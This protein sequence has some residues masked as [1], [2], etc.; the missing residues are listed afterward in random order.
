[1]DF[2]NV[3]DNDG[4]ILPYVSLVLDASAFFY[5][6]SASVDQLRYVIQS[7][8]KRAGDAANTEYKPSEVANVLFNAANKKS[9]A[10][11]TVGRVGLAI[12]GLSQSGHQPSIGKAINLVADSNA[13]SYKTDFQ[14]WDFEKQAFVGKPKDIAGDARAVR[15]VFDQ[16]RKV[17]HICAAR[18]ALNCYLE[19]LG[20]F[21]RA[22][23][24]DL[25]YVSTVAAFQQF[26][27]KYDKLDRSPKSEPL[28]LFHIGFISN[29]NKEIEPVTPSQELMNE[30]MGD[31]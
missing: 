4:E 1:M 19:P 15:R 13:K 24:A 23:L 30:I 11:E 29:L 25:A 8:F 12:W 2:L 31:F 17:V 5:G 10:I 27:S 9:G 22:P 18:T 14:F 26:F 21:E 7:E 28:N 3:T 16:Y 20:P 6:E